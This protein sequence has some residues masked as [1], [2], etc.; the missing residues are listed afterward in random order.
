[1]SAAGYAHLMCQALM[2]HRTKWAQVGMGCVCSPTC[3][4]GGFVC[5]LACV[6]VHSCT[7]VHVCLCVYLPMSMASDLG[8]RDR[9]KEHKCSSEWVPTCVYIH[10]RGVTISTGTHMH[11]YSC[12]HTGCTYVSRRLHKA[13][14]C[15]LC[16]HVWHGITCREAGLSAGA[17]CP[18]SGRTQSV[19]AH[20]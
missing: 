20:F 14:M 5:A 11:V 6:H 13:C 2:S 19:D 8:V 3:T 4:R 1:M 7:Q 17:G 15:M 10:S 16:P 9:M 12:V 18:C